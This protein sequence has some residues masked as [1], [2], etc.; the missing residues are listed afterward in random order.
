VEYSRAGTST[1]WGKYSA[2]SAWGSPDSGLSVAAWG[3]QVRLIYETA[4]NFVQSTLS[5]AGW[6]EMDEI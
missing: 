1:T 5:G 3:D 4:G 2:P 6:Q